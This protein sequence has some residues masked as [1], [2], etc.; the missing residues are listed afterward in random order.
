MTEREYVSKAAKVFN[1]LPG[2][3]F[4]VLQDTGGLTHKKP[5]DAFFVHQ[6]RH[7]SIE[8]KCGNG[9]LEEHQHKA[10]KED[11]EVGAR[12]FVMRFVSAGLAVILYDAINAET[13]I[14]ETMLWKDF[15]NGGAADLL[16]WMVE[17]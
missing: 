12:C 17:L 16:A 15:D 10:L 13:D 5:Y 4:R 1:T 8:G 3:K 6:G 14:G 9:K 11:A 2:V 7:F